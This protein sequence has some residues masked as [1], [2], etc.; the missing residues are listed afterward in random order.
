MADSPFQDVE[1]HPD[2]GVRA[3]IEQG[4]KIARRK[5]DHLIAG[6]RDIAGDMRTVAGKKSF[7]EAD[8]AGLHRII[9]RLESATAELVAAGF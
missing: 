3:D 1:A 6:L 7:A 2:A 4:V 9:S 5:L 8:I